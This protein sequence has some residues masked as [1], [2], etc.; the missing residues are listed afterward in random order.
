MVLLF[1]ITTSSES[2]SFFTSSSALGI[3]SVFHFGPFNRCVMVLQCGFNL[4]YFE[5]VVF[6]LAFSNK[7]SAILSF[8]LCNNVPPLLPPS[9]PTFKIFLLRSPVNKGIVSYVNSCSSRGRGTDRGLLPW[10]R[11]NG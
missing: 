2:S 11:G 7:K 9:P 10:A 6:W 3:V 1:Y 5:N 4:Q 8:L